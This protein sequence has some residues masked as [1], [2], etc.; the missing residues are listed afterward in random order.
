VA[1]LL[2]AVPS[3]SHLVITHPASDLPATATATAEM[4]QRLNR[5]MAQQVIPRSHAEISRFFHGLELVEPG[6]VRGPEWRPDSE[7]GQTVPSNMWSG[8]ARKP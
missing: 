3:G 4:A 8:L 6:I 5:L 2:A 7:R 1:R